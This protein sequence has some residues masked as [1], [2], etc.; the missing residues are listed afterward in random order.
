MD[1][2]ISER[3]SKR[4]CEYFRACTLA[5]TTCDL[6]KTDGCVGANSRLFIIGG[7]CE[8]TK[9]L[10]VDNAIGEFRNDS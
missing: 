8:V 6:A 4:G 2:W 7:L 10:A 1:K 9:Q 3:S 5:K